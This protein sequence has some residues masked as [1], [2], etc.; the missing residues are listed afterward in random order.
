MQQLTGMDAAF[1]HMETPATQG[2]VGSLTIFD[3]KTAPAQ[4]GFEQIKSILE[5]RLHLAPVLRRRL[6]EVPLGLD[7]PYWIEDPKKK[8]IE[9]NKT[10]KQ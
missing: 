3:A 2:H 4:F 8:R 1:L 5:E 6:V 10:K 9:K 7:Q